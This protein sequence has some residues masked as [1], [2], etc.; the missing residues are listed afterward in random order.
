VVDELAQLHVTERDNASVARIDGEIDVSNAAELAERV[1]SGMADD[2]SMLVLDLSHTTYVDSSGLR[3]LFELRRRLGS[4]RRKLWVV[5][6]AEAPVR[7]LLSLTRLEDVLPVVA[8]VD[9]ALAQ[10]S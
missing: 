6:P 4:R 9:D 7:R 10:A 3:L 8:S 2:A 1:M 5:V